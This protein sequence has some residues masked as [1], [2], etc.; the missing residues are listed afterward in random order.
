[1]SIGVSGDPKVSRLGERLS[2]QRAVIPFGQRPFCVTV[3]LAGATIPTT[4]VRFTSRDDIVAGVEH[5]AEAAEDMPL[6][7]PMAQMG[8]ITRVIHCN[9]WADEHLQVAHGENVQLQA[10]N[11]RLRAQLAAVTG[12]GAPPAQYIPL[13]DREDDLFGGA[14]QHAAVE[15]AFD[16]PL[17]W[18]TATYHHVPAADAYF[19]GLYRRLEHHNAAQSIRSYGRMAVRSL[20]AIFKAVANEGAEMTPSLQRSFQIQVGMLDVMY[21][22]CTR[23]GL[24]TAHLA[25]AYAAGPEAAYRQRAQAAAATQAKYDLAAGLNR[26]QRGRG[27][28]GG[29]RGGHGGTRGRGNNSSPKNA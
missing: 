13:C 23:S 22:S 20:S 9:V 5:W 18:G 10:E 21:S 17:T 12:Q 15:I 24:S 7:R 4:T 26:Q 14:A 1:M 29:S 3:V 16:D 6:S 28:G 2:E 11:T 25:E 19:E 8:P 27:N